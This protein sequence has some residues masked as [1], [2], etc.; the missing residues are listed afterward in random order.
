VT[1]VRD[2]FFDVLRER[3]LT[4]LFSNP[5][6]TE[7]PLLVGLPDDLRFV[8][9]LHEASVVGLATGYALGRDDA[10]L[11]VL[12]TTAGLGNAV[13]ALAT[14]RVNRVPLVVLVGQ[15]D[16]RQLAFEPFL[17]GRLATLAGEYPVWVSEPARPQDLPAAVLRASHEA[18]T[19]RGP[20]LVV[21]PMDDWA[22]PADLERERA[23]PERVVRADA[24]ADVGPLVELLAVAARPALVAGSLTD[25]TALVAL[26]ERIGAHVW[27][28]S[29]SGLAGFPQDHPQFAGHLPADRTRL[30]A[31]LDRYD[32]V[33]CVGA[34]AF[35]QYPYADGRFAPEGVRV[36][37]VTDDPDEAHRA[38]AELAV[39]APP[40]AVC[41]ELAAR[42]PQREGTPP[43]PW[44]AEPLP[45]GA[46]LY[47]GH[48]LDALQERLPRDAVVVE[49]TPSSRPALHRRL[50]AVEP[51]GFV[52]AAMGG[53]GFALP[54]AVGLRM[55][56][57]ERPVVA[58]VGDGSALYSIQALWSAVEYG[59]GALFVILNN[60]GYAVMDRLAERHEGG[61]PWPQVQHLDLQALAGGFGCPAR[62]VANYDELTAVL[63]DALVRENEP[64]LLEVVVAPDPEFAP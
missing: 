39:L 5:G 31:V 59:V 47:A 3:G 14:A 61:V 45:P 42:L 49:E 50:R 63:D 54:A 18:V 6:S 56:R 8:L 28:E 4:T 1:T 15:Q 2:S 35:K 36:A 17:T 12:H 23:A 26:A 32:V 9:A 60:G 41:R 44:F 21:A 43:E 25:W 24:T 27:Q 64:L 22:A 46:P 53:L 11:A 29:F 16:R 38:A 48:V 62:R 40:A 20:A 7:V 33:V 13:A 57:P 19:H 55:A 34:A 51:L 58:V 10:A 52:S 30:R 37:V